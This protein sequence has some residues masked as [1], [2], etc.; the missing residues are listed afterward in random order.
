MSACFRVTI[1]GPD[2]QA[3]RPPEVLPLLRAKMFRNFD[4]RRNWGVKIRLH[5]GFYRISHGSSVTL[6]APVS[7]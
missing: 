7:D 6:K 3:A 2:Q 5:I 1:K 4:V